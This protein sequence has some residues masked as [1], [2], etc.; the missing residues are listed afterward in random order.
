MY[1][2]QFTRF[3]HENLLELFPDAEFTV[4]GKSR[5]S[6]RNV[7]AW[8]LCEIDTAHGAACRRARGE[9]RR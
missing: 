6:A 3:T 8:I 1:K 2:G 4:L 9:R 7:H 5:K